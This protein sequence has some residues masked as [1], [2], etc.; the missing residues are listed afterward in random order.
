MTRCPTDRNYALHL[1]QN[2][3]L[4]GYR[5]QFLCPRQRLGQPVVY[6]CG[7]SLGLQPRNS[8]SFVLREMDKWANMAVEGHFGTPDPWYSYHE[9]LQGPLARIVGANEA[10]VIAMNSLTVNLH[11]LMVSFYK[12]TAKRYRILLEHQAFPS[13]RYAVASQVQYHGYDP[14]DA[15]IEIRPRTGEFVLRT[16][17]IETILNTHG[18]SIALVCLGG[19]H[20]YSGQVLPMADI[21]HW[22]HTVGARVGFDLAHAVGNILLHLHD[23]NVDFA[24]W[25]SYKYLN[26]GPGGVGC[27]FVHERHHHDHTLPR[28]A[29]WWGHNAQTRFAMP[30]HFDAQPGAAGWQM[31]NAPVLSM[32]SLRAS[33]QWFDQVGMTAL[34][35]K[36]RKLNRY[37]LDLIEQI[38]NR[39]FLPITPA[40]EQDRGCQTSMRFQQPQQ[41]ETLAHFLREQGIVC[42]IRGDVIRV[43][44]V[45]LYNSFCDVWYLYE[46][47]CRFSSLQTQ[48]SSRV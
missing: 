4:A 21:T 17:D 33:L 43:A 42:D 48:P 25:C 6:L 34:C 24:T 9:L 3:E 27:A 32:A 28:L 11:L 15:I 26:A 13:D 40:A 10:E 5:Q 39:P 1:D 44:P 30:E 8:R 41:A 29:G 23:W 22:A 14:S 18:D 31:S 20:Y 16:E 2:D 12:P 47:L 19:V 37:L 36:S 35:S 38:P 46:A 45:P 7:N